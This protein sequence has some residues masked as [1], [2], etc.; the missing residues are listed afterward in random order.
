[1]HILSIIKINNNKKLKLNTK[2]LSL[3]G[4][5]IFNNLAQLGI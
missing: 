2:K 1:M 3:I 5:K 4:I